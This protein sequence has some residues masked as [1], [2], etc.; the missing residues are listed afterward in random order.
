MA[1]TLLGHGRQCAESEVQTLQASE[2][3]LAYAAFKLC[4]CLIAALSLRA[5]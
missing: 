2:T 3:R 5:N 1:G 4:R